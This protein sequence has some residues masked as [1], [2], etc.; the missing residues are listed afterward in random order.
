MLSASK[1]AAAKD[2][3]DSNHNH[4]EKSHFANSFSV[5]G[6]LRQE[7]TLTDITLKVNDNNNVLAASAKAHKLVL[8]AASDYFRTMFKA[9]FTESG[10]DS[11]SL[12]G[13]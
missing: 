11:L 5:L 6:E 8:M 1:E 12:H 7:G 4:C 10:L 3:D 13:N 2:N 9:C